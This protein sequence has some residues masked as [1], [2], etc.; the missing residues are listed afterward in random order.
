M[1]FKLS[2]LI[3]VYYKEMVYN[4]VEC[5]ESLANQKIP[6]DEI[7][8]VKDGILTCEL[9]ATLALWEKKL[10][11]KIIGY[12]E[13]R[14]IAYALNYGLKY[15][16]NDIV[17]RMDSDDICLPDRF[18]RQKEIFEN[19]RNLVL[20]SGYI[21]EFNNMPNDISSVRKVPTG[22]KEIVKYLKKRNA[23]NHMAVMYR[24]S[25]VISVG[26]YEEIDGF[27]DYDLWIKLVQAGFRVDNVPEILVYVRVGN[28]MI[29]RR[30]GLKYAE[31]EIIFLN[32]Q[33][34][35]H[36]ISMVEFI[37][38]FISRVPVRLFPVKFLA[39]AY[40]R[41]LRKYS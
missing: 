27:E 20:L 28:N 21:S 25:A 29:S 39:V 24:K 30:S 19:D 3:P 35:R 23:F 17:A 18:A 9:E 15:C 12:K 13:N 16:S 4:F 7:V 22:S 6:A 11:L 5:L 31:K 37:V 32:R 36:F 38:L 41:F 10:P 8:V 33:R 2:V 34:K 14:G 1:V 40:Y 26:G